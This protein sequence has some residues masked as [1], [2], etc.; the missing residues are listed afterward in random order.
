MTVLATCS[1]QFYFESKI[2]L[3]TFI[4]FLDSISALPSFI[5]IGAT[6]SL[7]KKNTSDF[8]LLTFN[9]DCLGHFVIDSRDFQRFV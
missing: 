9:S 4:D 5:T 1:D 7:L 3:S 2:T 8:S 6:S